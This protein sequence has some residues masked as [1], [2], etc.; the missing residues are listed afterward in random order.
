MKKGKLLAVLL[1]M[2]LTA[3]L[4]PATAFAD[5]YLEWTDASAI[6]TSGTYR[7][8][9]NV[10]ITVTG[11]NGVSIGRNTLVLDLNGHTVTFNASKGNAITLSTGGSLTIEDSSPD[12]TGKITNSAGSSAAYALIYANGGEVLLKGGALEGYGAQVLYVNTAN[13]SAT[14]SGGSVV[15]KSSSGGYAMYINAG[16]LTVSG[17]E[18]INEASNGYALFAN[19][20][21]QVEFTAGQISNTGK[22]AHAVQVNGEQTSVVMTD[23]LIENTINGSDAVFV[24]TGSFTINGGTIRQDCTYSSSA[25]IYANNSAVAVNING[26]TIESGAMGVYAAFTP[27]S[28]T[29]GTIDAATYGFQTRYATINPAEGKTVD[30]SAGTALL[31]TFRGSDNEILGGSFD[32]PEISRV[33]TSE[34]PSITTITGGVFTT[35]PADDVPDGT[36]VASITSGDNAPVFAVGAGDIAAKAAEAADGDTIEILSGDVTLEIEVDGVIVK[37]SGEGDVVVNDNEVSA[38]SPLTVCVHVWGEPVWTWSDDGQSATATF[39]CTKNEEHT[40]SVTATVTSEVTTAATC[41]SKGT[42]T[43]TAAVTFEEESYTDTKALENID[44]IPHNA[45]MTAAKD[46]TTSEAGNIAYWHCEACGKYF[47]DEDCTTEIELDSTVIPKL[48][49]I[50]AGDGEEWQQG[51]QTGV[52]FTSDAAADDFVKVLVDGSEISAENYEKGEGDTI[53][54]TL[55]PEYLATLTV[56]NHT[57]AIASDN[58]TAEAGFAILAA[59]SESEPEV[60]VTGDYGTVI[61][62]MLILVSM[63]GI[64]LYARNKKAA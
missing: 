59:G 28:V 60:P 41:T 29:G 30:V 14:L 8:E 20:G 52:S 54:I 53:V 18:I 40:E 57:V 42:T 37:N 10:E 1:V 62:V 21:A 32:S 24:N 55:K 45:E 38:D 31:Y 5:E 2:L 43:Y 58:G 13:G 39:T 17:A 35:S 47:S 61:W 11:Y 6:P 22:N 33:Y 46:P 64:L 15:N 63:A 27:V 3:A 7:L 9:T 51:S 16:S 48:P 12:G 56:G 50:T 36:P 44:I 25:A 23:G 49:V 19:A 34:E 26:G 4:L